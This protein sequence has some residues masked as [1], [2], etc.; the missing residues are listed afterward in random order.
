VIK[1]RPDIM[2]RLANTGQMEGG[3]RNNAI[4]CR[5]GQDHRENVTEPQPGHEW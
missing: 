1:H 5:T 3:G 2:K 4:K